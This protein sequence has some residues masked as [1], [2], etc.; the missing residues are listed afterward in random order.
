MDTHHITICNDKII[1][2]VHLPLAGPNEM[3]ATETFARLSIQNNPTK[4]NEH[5]NAQPMTDSHNSNESIFYQS[6]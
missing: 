2:M 5:T 3:N 4:V 1:H 6:I